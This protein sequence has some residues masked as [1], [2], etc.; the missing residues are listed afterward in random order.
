MERFEG[1]V[2]V[3]AG[4]GAGMGAETARRLASEGASV[5]VGDI[6]LDAAEATAAEIEQAGG[7]ALGA[8]FDLAD[9]PSIAAL[10][11]KAASS[12]GGLDCLFN[13][14]ADMRNETYVKDTDAVDIDVEHWNHILNVNLTG[15][16]LGCRY[17]IPQMLKRG[18]GS[19]VCTSSDGAFML[20]P[21]PTN[22]GYC[23]S[24]L[25]IVALVR[26]VVSRWGREGI[27]CNCISP[28]AIQT[29]TAMRISREILRGPDTEYATAAESPSAR[30]GLPADIAG[31]AAFLLSDDACGVNAQ[32][33]HVN[34]GSRVNW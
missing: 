19:I 22:V 23:T 32:V 26:H 16:M 17:A 34:N 4:G 21:F 9:E 18:G 13:V 31:A 2:A 29:D 7:I 30:V 33:I 6:N 27:R 3:I 11:Q 14:A 5:V 28:G 10:M 25:A 8:W 20:Y 15:Y 1:K 12:Y 24:K